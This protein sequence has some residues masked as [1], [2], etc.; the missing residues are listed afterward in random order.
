MQDLI[1][2]TEIHPAQL[3]HLTQT[4]LGNEAEF[5]KHAAIIWANI[6][7]LLSALST[8][9]P[10]FPL[11]PFELQ[12]P[13]APRPPAAWELPRTQLKQPQTHSSA[14]QQCAHRGR[15]H[16]AGN[17]AADKKKPWKKLR[18]TL[19]T[20]PRNV[21]NHTGPFD[22]DCHPRAGTAG[23]C[24]HRHYSLLLPPSTSSL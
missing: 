14:A 13:K 9:P 3:L 8:V 12:P 10:S 1:C 16:G 19:M 2:N 21:K 18:P 20:A 4:Q 15:A 22:A 11:N 23:W 5:A 17:G 24:N 7:I 6:S